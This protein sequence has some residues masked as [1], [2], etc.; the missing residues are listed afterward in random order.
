MSSILNRGVLTKNEC[1]ELI[2]LLGFDPETLDTVLYYFDSVCIAHY[3]P[4]FLPDIVFVDPQVPLDKISELTKHAISLRDPTSFQSIPQATAGS[5]RRFRDEGIY[6]L[7]I[8]KDF[9]EHYKEGI[10]TPVD[11]IILMKE[12][13]LVVPLTAS[14]SDEDSSFYSTT[15]YLMPTLLRSVSPSELDKHRVFGS[16]AAPLLIQFHNAKSGC[17]ACVRRGVFCCLVVYLISKCDWKVHLSSGEV[18]FLK[19]NCIK[20]TLPGHAIR[21]TL[22]DTFTQ[23]EVHV[24]ARAAVCQRLCVSIKKNLLDGIE[25]ACEVLHYDDKPVV[26]FLCPHVSESGQVQNDSMKPHFADID[27][28]DGLWSCSVAKD[29]L[30]DGELELKHTVWIE[31]AGQDSYNMTGKQFLHTCVVLAG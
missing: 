21:I 17:I 7:D 19:R 14:S 31:Y 16:P 4:K 1:L 15:E 24:K 22:I 10:F 5:W 3:Y 11:M 28:V 27:E 2:V 23:I 12:L 29:D 6:T 30:I 25:E 20:F 18:I 13:L 9:P 26:G 8:L